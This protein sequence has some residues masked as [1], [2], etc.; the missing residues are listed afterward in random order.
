[1]IG[2]PRRNLPPCG[3]GS[4]KARSDPCCVAPSL[5]GHNTFQNEESTMAKPLQLIENV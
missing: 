1:L 4:D 5:A 3:I 2:Q